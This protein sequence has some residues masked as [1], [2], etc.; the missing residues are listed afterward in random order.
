MYLSSS[1]ST[2]RENQPHFAPRCNRME[3]LIHG[4]N[5]PHPAPGRRACTAPRRPRRQGHPTQGV[6]RQGDAI[7]RQAL[8]HPQPAS[9]PTG[10]EDGGR[11]RDRDRDGGTR[12]RPLDADRPSGRRRARRGRS[13]RSPVRAARRGSLRPIRPPLET[14]HPGR[15][16]GLPPAGRS[17]PSSGDVPSG[18]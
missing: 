6:R 16:P 10:L 12:P 7:R 17:C 1:S 4:R 11:R 8:L 18:R 14:A 15:Q 13:R 5:T 3:K 2:G 9:G